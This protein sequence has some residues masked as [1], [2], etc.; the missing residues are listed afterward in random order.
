MATT[1]DV[2]RAFR[3]GA[4]EDFI[5]GRP[6]DVYSVNK[7]WQRW[8]EQQ[9]EEESEPVIPGWFTKHKELIEKVGKAASSRY[10]DK[11]SQDSIGVLREQFELA[12]RLSK[13]VTTEDEMEQLEEIIDEDLAAWLLDLPFALARFGLVQ[14]AVEMGRAWAAI[15]ERANFLGDRAVILAEAGRRKEAHRQIEE[16]FHEFPEDVWVRIK[17]GD[18]HRALGEM[19]MAERSY[20]HALKQ[21]VEDYDRDG[22]LERLIPM[23]ENLGRE[24]E[25]RAL[26]AAEESRRVV[27]SAGPADETPAEAR[28]VSPKIGRNDP[29]PCG[30]GK[31]FKKCH[32][33]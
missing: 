14:E 3:D 13:V 22:A 5:S 23:L 10:E 26:E 12:D 4:R 17:I 33:M 8:S 7:Q 24:D 9:Q 27:K 19:E 25:A 15:T 32:G 18:A 11:S 31:K 28:P 2:R 29:C 16:A 20:H 21:A 6:H 30:S 1:D